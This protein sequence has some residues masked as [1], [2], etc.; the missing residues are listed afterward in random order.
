MVDPS[1]KLLF[2]ENISKAFPGVPS[3]DTVNFDLR[4]VRSMFLLGENGAG[5]STL[6]KILSGAYQ[7]I[8]AQFI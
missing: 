2:M 4:R 1:T 5:K 3:L 8:R 7:K 6:I